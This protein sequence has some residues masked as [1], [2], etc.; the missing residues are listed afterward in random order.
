MSEATSPQLTIRQTR[1]E[2]R[3]LHRPLQFSLIRRLFTYT[4]PYARRRNALLAI[5]LLRS[6]QLPLLA[7][8]VGAVIGGPIAAGDARGAAWG[9]AGFALLAIFTEFV[10]HF[11]MLLA[12][13]LGEAVVHD[14]R[15]QLFEHLQR[16][17]MSFYNTT[18]L[19]RIISRMVSDVEVVRNGVQ[20]VLF[21]SLVQGGQMLVAAAIMLYY[22]WALFLVV[23][24]ISPVLYG[25]NRALRGRLSRAMR[26]TQESFSRI[27]AT[28]AETVNGI[29]VTQGFV[30]QDVNA[31]LFG[32]LVEDHSRYNLDMA[33]TSGLLMP[34]LEINSQFFIAMLL[35]LG[36]YRA[37]T[38]SIGMPIG[39]LIQFFFL[40]G[41]FFSP[42]QVLGAQYNQALIAMAGA[43]RV[44]KLL[45]REPEWED[46]PD[47]IALP[48]VEG[49]VEFRD[50][51]FGY[52]PE[53][54]V[55]HGINLVAKPGQTVALVGHTGSGK[56]T[57]VGLIAKFYLPTQG[58]VFIDGH[59]IRTLRGDS[60]H[61]HMGIV[62]QE[63]F[64]FTGTIMDNIRVG[65]PEATDAEV[66]DA[67]RKLDCLDLLE[68]LPRGLYTEVGERGSSISLG[69]RQLICF[70]RAMLADPRILVLDEATSAV[71]SMTEARIQKSLETL[72]EGRTSFVIAHR[73]ST[74]RDADQVLVL[75]QGHI[76]E[77]G[78]HSELL[79]QGEVYNKLYRQFVS[80]GIDSSQT[81]S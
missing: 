78:T 67:A 16:M 26:A 62:Q 64:L 65:R 20:N 41:I 51:T 45:D 81:K 37:L 9:I 22:D 1:D 69:Q 29:R 44:F 27:T 73:L 17:P 61:R 59:E 70:T 52:H 6:I 74:I 5:V 18:K 76:V 57:T 25:I 14:M 8:A 56:T 2:E 12:L 43:E 24:S 79:A 55:L 80:S 49:R 40:A 28:M 58:E 30:R 48:S 35:V 66:I 42:L 15:N 54:P 77:R 60:L 32:R 68:S 19:G 39:D 46:A 63:N 21:V 3:V 4:N 10:M 75:D 34:L 53:T 13:E 72:L 38:P 71:D 47:A 33:K 50:L 11:R 31:G 23:L 36:G 7:W